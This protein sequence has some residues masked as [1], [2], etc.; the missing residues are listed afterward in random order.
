VVAAT[1]GAWPRSH[2][3]PHRRGDVKAR[4]LYREIKDTIIAENIDS[5]G[6]SIDLAET[7]PVYRDIVRAREDDPELL[8]GRRALGA[9][10]LYPVL[11]SGYAVAEDDHGK[12]KLR[13]LATALTA[14]FV[15]Y[16]IV[17]GRET[18]V[19]ETT[20]YEVA[21]DLRRARPRQEMRVM[22]DRPRNHSKMH[23]PQ[24]VAIYNL[25][26]SD[27]APPAG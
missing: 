22:G 15:H 11:L 3:R 17:G 12:E 6:L 25:G 5:L 16:N 1:H 13:L 19:M 4:K 23:E 10:A 14:M 27:G 7:A 24:I 18:T 26:D 8:E 21:A 2:P 9:K 20:V